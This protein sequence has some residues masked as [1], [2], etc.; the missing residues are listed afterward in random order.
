MAG[1]AASGAVNDAGTETAAVT[2]AA[3][4]P[5]SVAGAAAAGAVSDAGTG[6]AA[7]PATVHGAVTGAARAAVGAVTGA[8]LMVLLPLPPPVLVK[9]GEGAAKC[10]S[11]WAVLLVTGEGAERCEVLRGVLCID[12]AVGAGA[13]TRGRGVLKAAGVEGEGAGV[14]EAVL[15]GAAPRGTELLVLL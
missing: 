9:G 12:P 2:G 5:I 15:S 7:E 8:L 4:W 1:A 3:I 10:G 6:I 14:E 13:D 11:V